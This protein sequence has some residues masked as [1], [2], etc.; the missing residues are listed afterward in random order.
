MLGKEFQEL[1]DLLAHPGWEHFKALVLGPN[2]PKLGRE[3]LQDKLVRDLRGAGRSGD[4]VKAAE[5][6]GQLDILTVIFSIPQQV[7]DEAIRG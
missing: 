3:P 1:Q 6:A 7:V 2:N 4:G 5:Y